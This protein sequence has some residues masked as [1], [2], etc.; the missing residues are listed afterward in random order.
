MTAAGY[1]GRNGQAL[2]SVIIRAKQFA[3]AYRE[4]EEQGGKRRG[5]RGIYGKKVMLKTLFRE[6]RKDFIATKLMLY[7]KR[8]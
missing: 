1:I 3:A 5:R 7:G 2:L 8:R 6:K 4:K